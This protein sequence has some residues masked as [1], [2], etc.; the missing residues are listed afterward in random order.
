MLIKAL[1]GVDTDRLKEEKERGISIELG[2]AYLDL[3]SGIRAGIIDVPGHERFIKNMLAGIG[4]IDIVLLVVAADEGVMPQT[5]EHVDIVQVLGINRGV[6]AVTKTDLVEQEWLD[7]V[8]E[9][10][11]GYIA[12]TSLADA[13]I[14]PV[15]AATG[16]GL[17]QLVAVVD[18]LVQAAQERPAAGPV[19]LPIDRVFTIAG[20]G[21]VVTGT[22]VSGTIEEGDS[23]AVLP[24]KATARVRSLQVHKTKTGTVRA[25]QRVAVNL[26]GLERQAVA[27]GDVLATPGFFTPTRTLD[28]RIFL[29]KSAKTLKNRARVRVHLGASEITGRVLLLDRDELEPEDSCYAQFILDEPIVAGRLD[30]FVLR[31][32]SPVTTIGGGTVLEPVAKRHKRFR[33]DVLDYLGTVE[34]G[35]PAEKV[36]HYLGNARAPVEAGGLPNMLGLD[37]DTV[38]AA[39]AEL[40]TAKRIRTYDV[41]NQ[42]LLIDADYYTQLARRVGE[43]VADYHRDYPLREGYPREELRSRLFPGIGSRVFQGFLQ[44]LADDGAVA[45]LPQVVTS[46]GFTGEPPA[47]VNSALTALED[48][49]REARFQPPRWEDA[50]AQ[51]NIAPASAVEYLNYLIRAGMLVK[52][53]EEQLIHRDALRDA[54]N[55]IVRALQEKAEISLGEV[56]DLLNTSRKHALPLLEYLDAK[57]VT[58]RMGDTRVLMKK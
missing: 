13:P 43:L 23:L 30:R 25:G 45:L 7:L 20:F 1:T 16:S 47:A 44:K 56:R 33:K 4:G 32:V 5:R 11:R 29:L 51:L 2:F 27:R 26:A 19:R 15:S 8:V 48:V 31:S 37:K 41:D 34:T 17:K 40:A 6:V 39:V 50:F 36:A 54:Q 10:V 52:L 58:R 24:Q 14:V 42:R 3:P 18:E 49:Y 55:I 46:V 12:A 38:E 21:T 9:D 53:S 22:L 28:G 57:R 35:S